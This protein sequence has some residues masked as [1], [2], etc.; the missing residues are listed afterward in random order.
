M[1]ASSKSSSRASW[2]VQMSVWWSAGF[3]MSTPIADM[4]LIARSISVASCSY[5][6]PS[7]ELATN[8]CVQTCTWPRSAKPPLVKARNRFSVDAA[9]W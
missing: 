5:R 8:S 2:L 9:W 4:K 6:L 3:R 7:G 1:S